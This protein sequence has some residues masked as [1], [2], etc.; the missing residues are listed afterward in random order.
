MKIL[1][2]ASES[3]PYVTTGGLA[4][5]VGS[6][7]KAL[8]RAG[9]DVRICIPLYSRIDR[10]R[11]GIAFRQAL[12]VHMGGA[13][14]WCGL[15]ECDH[16]PGVTTWFIDHAA[17][18]GR[19]GIYD[20]NGWAYHDNNGRFAFH[21][22]AALQAC[23][24]T[25][26]IP[27]VLHA[28]D[29]QAAPGVAFRKTWDAWGSPLSGT[30]CVLTLH[31]LAYQGQGQAGDM[32]WM[33]F[34]PEHFTP[35]IFEDHGGINLLKGGIHFADA[36]T[37]VSPTYAREIQ[38]PIGGQ[39][40]HEILSR[41]THDL[42]GIL[43][44]IDERHYDPGTDASIAAPFSADDLAG[45]HECRR[46]LQRELGLAEDDTRCIVSIVSRI[47]PGKGFDLIEPVLERA[48]REMHIQF[49]LVGSGDPRYENWVGDLQRRHPGRVGNWIGYREDLAHKVYAGSDLYLMPSLYEPCGLSQMYA[50]R[51]GTL[52][53]VRRT[54]GLADT[55]WNYDE[56]DGGGDGF[57]FDD[58]RID[59]LYYTLGW[60]V[61]TFF[62]RPAHFDTMRRR[63]MRRDFSW[64][65]SVARYEDVYRHALGKIG[66]T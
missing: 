63:V 45:R 48:M 58:Y 36:I 13:E 23:K 42:F 20:Q 9:H 19:P 60:A 11:F 53:V 35:E 25:G 46:S 33:G 44:G 38:G 28:H 17:M 30:A 2:L 49:V 39:G 50:M 3:H 14:V 16:A 55:V 61:S 56:R 62:D 34:G 22:K 24:D 21:C 40:L 27:D 41:R 31:N 10:S 54:G 8:A 64:D 47:A 65:A 26:W 37:T 1:F 66:R 4:G 57:V 52:P 15:H 32:A 59:A 6:L 29:W 51:Y 43:N 18:F 12:C 5:V 7:P